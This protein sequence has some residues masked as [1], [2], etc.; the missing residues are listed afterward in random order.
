MTLIPNAVVSHVTVD[1][2]SGAAKGVWYVDRITHAHREVT[3]RVV[4]LCASTLES[5]RILLNSTSRQHPNGLGNSSGVLG[6]YLMDHVTGG[7]ASGVLSMLDPKDDTRGNRPNGICIARFRNLTERH[8]AFIRGYGFQGGANVVKWGHAHRLD[9]F[10]PSF[11]QAVRDSRPWT[12]NFG[13]FG[14]GLPRHESHCRLDDRLK[15]AWGI[16]AL[17]IDLHT[18]DNERRMVRDMADTAAEMLEAVGATE[19]RRNASGPGGAIH[20]VGTARM[21]NDPKTSFV[22]RW[23]QSHD[24][25]NL[26]LMDGT[27]FPSSA[28]QNPTI[29]IMALAARACDYL[30][31]ELRAGRV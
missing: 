5:T 29:T 3:A 23:Q 27:V 18:G 20:E 7:G 9:G 24:V 2:S 25:K 1:A 16:P 22:N 14:E 4:V 12:I 21:G 10:G 15:D 8:P 26:F 13:G 11:K 30:V 28:C 6:R 31:E 17:H 19:I